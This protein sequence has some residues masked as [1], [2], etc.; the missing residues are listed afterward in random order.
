MGLE[1]F[2]TSSPS[3][4]TSTNS[5]SSTKQPTFD[6]DPVDPEKPW[7]NAVIKDQTEKVVC[8]VGRRAFGPK[9][10][11]KTETHLVS[12]E[13]EEE[14]E[15]LNKLS[16]Q[17]HSVTLKQMFKRDPFKGQDFINRLRSDDIQ[18]REVKCSVCGESI[19]VTED[20]YT[21]IDGYRVHA[22]HTVEQVVEQI[23]GI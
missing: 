20:D 6:S 7:F 21:V 9:E 11:F 5:T 22:D 1:S 3:S 18:D 2:K 23:G 13:D 14:F 17:Y 10:R 16:K 19:I 15:R 8:F 4:S 12:V